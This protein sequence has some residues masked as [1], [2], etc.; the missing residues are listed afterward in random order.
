MP[1]P[2]EVNSWVREAIGKKTRSRIEKLLVHIPANTVAMNSKK[3][4]AFLRHPRNTSLI[5]SN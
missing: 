4:P 2:Y 3:H 1:P 5:M